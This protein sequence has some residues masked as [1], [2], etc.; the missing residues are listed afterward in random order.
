M[1]A[2]FKKIV[3][4]EKEGLVWGTACEKEPVAYGIFQLK[5]VCTIVD[6]M[7]LAEDITDMIEQFEDDV[8]S[9]QM[10]SMNKIS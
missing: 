2:L 8:Q 6:D 3:A 7:V 10:L 1:D 9:C 5:V 4:T